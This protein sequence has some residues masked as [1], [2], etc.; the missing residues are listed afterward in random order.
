MPIFQKLYDFYK[1]LYQYLKLFPQKDRY[2]LGQ[3]IDNLSLTIFEMVITAGAISK[4]KKLPYLEK[5]IATLNLL[6]ILIRLAKDVRALDNKKY[7]EL[8]ENLQEIG[9]MLGGW[10]KS[11]L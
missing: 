4:E 2:T 8:Q 7:L 9:K 1:L 11:L 3:K 10:K 5:S 6:K